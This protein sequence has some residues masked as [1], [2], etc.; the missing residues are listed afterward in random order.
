MTAHAAFL[1]V[2]EPLAAFQGEQRRQ[3]EAYLSAGDAP[4]P[5]DGVAMER[6]AALRAVAGRPPL[7]LPEVAEHAYVLEVDG[8]TLVCPWRTRLRALEA[9]EDFAVDLPDVV[10]EAFVPLPVVAAADDLLDAWRAG[11]PD[12]RSHQL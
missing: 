8:V 6:E 10:L 12:Q 5:A 11:H 3:W 9:L 1:R 4:G 7:V 2:Y